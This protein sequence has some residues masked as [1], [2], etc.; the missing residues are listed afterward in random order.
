[1]RVDEPVLAHF[2]DAVLA[3]KH[4]DRLIFVGSA[5]RFS[6][7]LAALAA[8][9]GIGSADGY[10]LTWAS[11][12]GGGATDLYLHGVEIERIRWR[13]RWATRKTLDIYIQETAAI[14]LSREL[15]K[16]SSLRIN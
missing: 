2:A 8:F 6:V 1:M 3:G 7:V 11:V 15:A 4:P 14:S 9:F 10:G 13:G 12:R 16:E 5:S